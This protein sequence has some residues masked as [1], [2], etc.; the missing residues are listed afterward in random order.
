MYWGF[1]LLSF[2]LVILLIVS[3]NKPFLPKGFMLYAVSFIMIV[4]L[5][6]VVGSLFLAID[7]IGRLFRWVA[8]RMQKPAIESGGG[9]GT[10]VSR[11]S[12]LSY[13][14]VGLA[15]VP[16]VSMLYGMAVTAFDFKVRRVRVRIPGL[17]AGFEGMKMVQLSDIH[18]GSFLS[19][20]SFRKS[21][22]LIMHEAPDMIVFTGDLVN[23]RASEAE[24]FIEAWKGLSAPLGIYSILGNH[25]YG[26]YVIWDSAKAKAANLERLKMIHQEMN[27]DLLLNEGRVIERNGSRI[28]LL[29]VENWGR[30]LRFPRKGNIDKAKKGLPE[31]PVKIL[32]SHD[33][34]HWDA[35]V[36]PDHPDIALTLSG[37]THGFQFGVEIPGIKWSPSQWLYKQWAGLYASGSQQIYVNRGLGFLGYMGRVGIKPE[38]TVLELHAG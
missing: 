21:V 36:L 31:L 32:L 23:D 3:Y 1:S 19:D 6:K 29:G 27:W 15:A 8:E 28:A 12:F 14:A 22:E 24:P 38:I 25:D 20:E 7:D 33:P 26:D 2:S 10:P 4:V 34:S 13:I 30:S 37:H 18:S 5:S 16:F 11:A 9:S 35:Q 17:P